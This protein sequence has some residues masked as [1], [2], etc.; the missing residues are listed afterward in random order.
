VQTEP[1]T[2]PIEAASVEAPTQSCA[3]GDN[4]GLDP[5]PGALGALACLSEGVER[6]VDQFLEHD[7][8]PLPKSA[9]GRRTKSILQGWSTETLSAEAT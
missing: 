3:D 2:L 9:E 6:I 7:Q 5:E 8:R 1:A 4:F